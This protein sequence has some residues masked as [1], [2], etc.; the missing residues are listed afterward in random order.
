MGYI[1]ASFVHRRAAIAAFLL[2]TIALPAHFSTQWIG[3]GVIGIIATFAFIGATW[4]EHLRTMEH[5]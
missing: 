1:A 2:L 3:L 4:H 5:T